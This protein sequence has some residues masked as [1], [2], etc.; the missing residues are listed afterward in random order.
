MFV[1]TAEACHLLKL[2]GVELLLQVAMVGEL[3]LEVA[4]VVASLLLGD[5]QPVAMVAMVALVQTRALALEDRALLILGDLCRCWSPAVMLV[6]HL[7]WSLASILVVDLCGD[8]ALVLV[9]LLEM[10]LILVDN[11]QNHGRTTLLRPSVAPMLLPNPVHLCHPLNLPSPA[12][13]L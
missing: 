8:L 2:V 1:E 12:V 10:D 5:L 4:M 9:E 6:H 3:L 7:C 13:Q 11:L